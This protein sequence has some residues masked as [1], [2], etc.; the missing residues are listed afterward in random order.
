M[1][2]PP[3]SNLRS[4]LPDESWFRFRPRGIHGAPHTTRVLVWA[5]AIAN[6]VAG[7]GALR[8]EEL[9]WAASV[10]D[11]GRV[12]DGTD[13]GHG[14]RS[15]EWVAMN[16]AETRPQTTGLDLAFVAELCR[17]HEIPDPKIGRLSLELLILK[18][19]DGLDRARLGDLDPRRLRLARSLGLVAAAEELER[20]TNRYGSVTAADI[21]DAAD[22]LGSDGA[23]R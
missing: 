18:D 17:W 13:Q 16:L 14:T 15:A 7:P 11:V 21:L 20:A 9:R 1:S 2:P 12:N 8:L 3:S 22:R 10:H 19:A 5:D 6:A 23:R 4:Y